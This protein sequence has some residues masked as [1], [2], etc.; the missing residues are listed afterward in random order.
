MQHTGSL[1]DWVAAHGAQQMK[2]A[3]VGCAARYLVGPSPP[4]C[5]ADRHH[6]RAGPICSPILAWYTLVRDGRWPWLL[7]GP[8]K[9]NGG[10][11]KGGPVVCLAWPL[12]VGHLVDGMRKW[13]PRLRR[14]RHALDLWTSSALPGP[15]RPLHACEIAHCTRI[16]AADRPWCTPVL[17]GTDFG[18]AESGD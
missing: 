8:Q 17:L 4:R 5:W 14:T 16:L 2:W 11:R 6:A 7:L 18:V 1:T 15:S 3:V 13:M 9:D 10:G 12:F